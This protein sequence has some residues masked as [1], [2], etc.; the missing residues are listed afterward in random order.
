MM[1][2]RLEQTKRETISEVTQNRMRSVPY[3][4]HSV[5]SVKSNRYAQ[6][7][8]LDMVVGERLNK[9]KIKHMRL[10]RE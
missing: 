10:G 7:L 2:Q 5:F 1:H 3:A 9:V 4:I 6:L 8:T